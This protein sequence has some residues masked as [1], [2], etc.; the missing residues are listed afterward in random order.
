[1]GIPN[2]WL[3]RTS[4]SACSM[5]ALVGSGQVLG[6]ASKTAAALELPAMPRPSA[7]P[8]LRSQSRGVEQAFSTAMS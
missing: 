2:S 8:N 6:K 1:M 3:V 5:V 4:F 7:V